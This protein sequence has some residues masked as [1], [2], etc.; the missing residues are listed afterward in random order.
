MK[1]AGA[2]P[3]EYKRKAK[4]VFQPGKLSFHEAIYILKSKQPYAPK[5][6]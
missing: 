3:R 2:M 1:T 6:E 5:K 4:N